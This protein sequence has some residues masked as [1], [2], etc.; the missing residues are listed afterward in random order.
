MMEAE[1]YP[2]RRFLELAGYTVLAVQILP[3]IGACAVE[4]APMDS[5]AVTS[6]RN[7]KLGQWVAHTHFLYVPLRLFSAPPAEGV[8]LSTTST[9]L[10]SHQV[11]LTRDQLT[12]VARGGTVQVGDLSGAH[13]YT[14]ALG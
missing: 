13:T 9:Y 2:R 11:A 3:W 7:S 1:V 6:S 12:A 10:H 4:K 5:L 14:I 8:T